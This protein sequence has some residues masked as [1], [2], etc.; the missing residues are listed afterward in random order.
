MI[1]TSL[2]GDNTW[3]EFMQ[4]L[5]IALHGTLGSYL[6]RVTLCM[7]AVLMVWHAFLFLGLKFVPLL[8]FILLG[9]LCS[10]FL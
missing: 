3:R 6:R 2:L 7:K 8:F 9:G 4:R 10:F 1:G 5:F